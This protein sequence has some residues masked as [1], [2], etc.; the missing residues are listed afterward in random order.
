[1]KKSLFF[2]FCLI[3]CVVAMSPY[4]ILAEESHNGEMPY[5]FEEKSQLRMEEEKSVEAVLPPE[6]AISNEEMLEML[7]ERM[8]NFD[9]EEAEQPDYSQEIIDNINNNNVN[10]TFDESSEENIQETI[11]ATD[12]SKVNINENIEHNSVSGTLVNDAVSSE[13]EVEPVTNPYKDYN[14]ENYKG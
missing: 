10:V 3:A 9:V 6:E 7:E 8:R 2:V 4:V 1:M 12:I 11:Q 14:S 13:F 5:Q